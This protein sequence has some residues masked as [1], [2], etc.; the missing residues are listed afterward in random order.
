[1]Y[2]YRGNGDV[3]DKL[4]FYLQ[5]Y[6]KR[7]KLY[8]PVIFTGV[9]GCYIVGKGWAVKVIQRP[10]DKLLVSASPVSEN[11]NGNQ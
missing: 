4:D 9:H 10:N 11:T 6:V 2:L 5:D 1:M 8:V 7:H 3:K